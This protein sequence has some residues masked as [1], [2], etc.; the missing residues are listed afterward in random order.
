MRNNG[1]F[2]ISLDFELHWGM[3][4]KATVSDFR[5]NLLGARAAIPQ[6]LELFQRYQIHA[7]WATV[8]FLFCR[9]RSELLAAVPDSLPHYED[10]AL[11]PY[12][13]LH[14]EIGNGEKDDPFHFAKSLV[15]RIANTPGQEL[16]SHTFSHYYC[17]EPGQT[18]QS[19]RD[20]L[21]MA[22]R[23]AYSHGYPITSLVFPRNQ[24]N[25]EYLRVCKAEG[26]TSYRG[27][28]ST[29]RYRAG[30]G[31]AS[32]SLLKRALRYLD[33]YVPISKTLYTL[34]PSEVQEP[35]NIPASRFL[36]PYNPKLKVFERVRLRRIKNELTSAAA[37]GAIYHLWWHPHNFGK[38]TAANLDFLEQVVKHASVLRQTKGLESLNMSEV[39]NQLALAATV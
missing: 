3:R 7:T 31:Q 15:D 19:F 25:P 17:L 14:D 32:N 33:S 12:T 6:M 30:D 28:L 18:K 1:I 8:G 29:Y 34:P 21:K 10:T 4:D 26:F 13:H 20:D 5:E 24:C 35:V 39:C 27:N 16:A 9:S 2:V 37:E 23:V 11:N 36:R 38:N 22:K